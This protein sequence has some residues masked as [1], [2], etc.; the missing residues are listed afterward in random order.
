MSSESERKM[1]SSCF[2]ERERERGYENG[3]VKNDLTNHG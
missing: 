1:K 2:L 3:G